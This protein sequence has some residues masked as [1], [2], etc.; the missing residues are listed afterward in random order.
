MYHEISYNRSMSGNEKS[1]SRHNQG[2]NLFFLV[3]VVILTFASQL[4]DHINNNELST[5]CQTDD[6]CLLQAQQGVPQAQIDLAMAH[7]SDEGIPRDHEQAA[8]WA[9]MAAKNGHV[10]AQ[11]LIG[12]LYKDGV[13]VPHDDIK[14]YAWLVTAQEEGYDLSSVHLLEIRERLDGKS[15]RTAEKIASYIRTHFIEKENNYPNFIDPEL[16]ESIELSEPVEIIEDPCHDDFLYESEEGR[17][18]VDEPLVSVCLDE[19]V[20]V[21]EALMYISIEIGYA[22]DI[23][24]MIARDGIRMSAIDQPAGD[25]VNEICKRASLYCNIEDQKLTVRLYQE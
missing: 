9:L 23:D 3:L 2:G 4:F 21:S 18:S 15:I 6:E 16:L 8:Y 19:L 10:E 12:S 25:T 7:L 20:P 13:G 5:L 11:F 24:P 17:Q 22:Y 14:A 1:I